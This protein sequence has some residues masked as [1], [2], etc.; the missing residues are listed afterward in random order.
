MTVKLTRCIEFVPKRHA[1]KA[2][3]YNSAELI[4]WVDFGSVRGNFT[5]MGIIRVDSFGGLLFL[6]FSKLIVIFSHLMVYIHHVDNNSHLYL[7]FILYCLIIFYIHFWFIQR[8]N[9]TL[10]SL[11]VGLIQVNHLQSGYI[12]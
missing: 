2:L 8:M 3:F 6:C 1:F 11:A 7:F 9:H 12:S 10:S 4:K 5:S